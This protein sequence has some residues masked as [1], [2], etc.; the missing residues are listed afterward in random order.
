MRDRRSD[1]SAKILCEAEV[2]SAAPRTCR[3][4]RCAL[5]EPIEVHPD[6]GG[7][8]GRIGKR[9]R[10][11]EGNASFVGTIEL[12]EKAALHPE[13]MKIAGQSWAERLDH[14][15]RGVRPLDL[16]DGDGPIERDDRG[17]LE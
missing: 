11:V 9:N 3:T 10:L 15:E 17:G 14:R 4:A 7:F 16:G 13:E 2:N 12:H 5:G 6:M 1:R 8:R